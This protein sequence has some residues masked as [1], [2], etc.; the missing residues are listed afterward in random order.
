[1]IQICND[2]YWKGMERLKPSEAPCGKTFDD[3]YQW[4]FCP[5]KLLPRTYSSS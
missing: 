3:L 5:H 2:I 1:M 4:T